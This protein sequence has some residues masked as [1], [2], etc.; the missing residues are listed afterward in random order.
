[1]GSAQGEILN[2]RPLSPDEC[3]MN[4]HYF[5]RSLRDRAKARAASLG[6][7]LK[8]WLT[9]VMEKALG[10]EPKPTVDAGG[11]VPTEKPLTGRRDL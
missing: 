7:T 3:D 11:T 1:M 9:G 2:R 5:A 4:V 6:L 10:V 8:E